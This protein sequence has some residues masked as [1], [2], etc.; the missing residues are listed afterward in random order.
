MS[1]ED[2][3]NP[4]TKRVIDP[5]RQQEKDNTSNADYWESKGKEARAKR[6]YEDEERA[7][8]EARERETNPPESPFQV[9]GSVN[10]GNIDIQQQQVE[11]RAMTEK[12]QADAQERM[13]TLQKESTDYR[14]QVH[15]IQLDMVQ[16]TLKA[17][18]DSL[19]KTINDGLAKPQEK[20]LIDQIDD[21]AKVAGVLGY[22][23]GDN[24]DTPPQVKLAI[25]KMDMENSHNQRQ[26]EWDKM[27][28]ER[29]W[30]LELKKLEAEG[31]ARM[32]QIQEEREKRSM[33]VSPFESIGMA[34]AR[35]LMDSGSEVTQQTTVAKKKRS[36]H[37]LQ[38]GENDSG[39]V[40]CPEC[41]QPIAIAPTARSTMC[42]SCEAVIS[43]NRIA[44][45]NPQ[46]AQ[47]GPESLDVE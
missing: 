43:I 29:N 9:K 37:Q 32:A 27:M 38:A 6:E 47:E 36:T 46:E 24:A 17:Q 14:D 41:R 15:K 4:R 20:G 30:Q 45:G 1:V 22:N 31:N 26:F 18:I 8:R 44:Q 19:T 21:I 35:G 42:P 7:A 10:L 2:V 16:S 25:M 13:E 28:S 33:L 12:I 3:N 23:R 40:D 11:L 5:T 34:L 39:V